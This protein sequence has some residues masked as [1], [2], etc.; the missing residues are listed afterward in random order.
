MLQALSQQQAALLQAHADGMRL[1]RVLVEQMLDAGKESGPL[2]NLVPEL[3][4]TPPVPAAVDPMTSLP[5]TRH[6]ASTP[7]V[8]PPLLPHSTVIEPTSGGRHR[9]CT[10]ATH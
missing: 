4:A 5:A 7:L 3:T 9:K 8:P 6:S 1:Q 10:G 2:S